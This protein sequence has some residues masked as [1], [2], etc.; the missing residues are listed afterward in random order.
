MTNSDQSYDETI[1]QIDNKIVKTHYPR[2]NNENVLVFVLEKDP[3][4]FLKTDQIT[5]HC[6]VEVDDGYCVENGFASKLFSMLTESIDSQVVSS[7]K[8][9]FVP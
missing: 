3:N 6:V 7:N 1:D 8:T 5:I 9:K 2:A 4:L